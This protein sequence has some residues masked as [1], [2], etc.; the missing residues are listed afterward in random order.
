[1]RSKVTHRG[2]VATCQECDFTATA[3]SWDGKK[4]PSFEQ[5]ASRVREHAAVREHVI[6]VV[7]TRSTRLEVHHP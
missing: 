7:R 1:M 2:A 3:Q 6:T 4:N 5:L